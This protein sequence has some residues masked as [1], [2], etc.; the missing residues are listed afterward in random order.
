MKILSINAG[1]SSMKFTAY[2]MPEKVELISGYIERI[3]IIGSFYTLKINGEKIEKTTEV[4]N[5]KQA[6]EIIVDEL[7]AYNIVEKLEEIK[8]LGH[9]IVQGGAYF[10]KSVEVNQDVLDKIEE[11][12]PLAPLHNPAALVG[13]RAALEVFPKAK[14]VVV[15]DTA[16]HQTMDESK[17]LY[18]LPYDWNEKYNVRKFGAHGTSH[19]YVAMRANEILKKDDTKLIT[20]HL[21]SGASISAVVNGKCEN[22]SMGLTPNAGLIM[23]TRCGDID[24]TIVP[25]MV[26][27]GMEID[28]IDR[29]MNKESGFLG[30]SGHYSDARDI[31]EA[32]KENDKRAIL[33]RDMFV[34]RVTDYIAKYYFEMK[35]VDAIVFTAGMG[36]KSA[37]FRAEIMK[38]LDVIGIYLDEEAN[39][40]AFGT[41]GLISTKDSKIPCYVIPTNE[42]LMIAIDTYDLAK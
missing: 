27:K 38:R 5:H 4:K 12:A 34:D 41:E 2:E 42:E 1:S 8:G 39:N 32:C 31:V 37:P 11:L 10:D 17:Y 13:I 23:G 24:A 22:T 21:G 30:I 26:R 14:Q 20:C 25:Y 3:G 33:A 36:E 35:G 40:K 7:K 29:I 19:K 15:F 18:A 6:F 28:E 9:R 16:F